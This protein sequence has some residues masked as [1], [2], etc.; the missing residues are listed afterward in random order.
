LELPDGHIAVLGFTAE[1]VD[2]SVTT[3]TSI[4]ELDSAG[5]PAHAAAVR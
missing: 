5:N 2:D 4:W 3:D 1:A